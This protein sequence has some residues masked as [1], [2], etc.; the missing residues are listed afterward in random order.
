MM[1]SE[2]SP[3]L[4]WPEEAER[5]VLGSILAAACVSIDCGRRVLGEAQ[6]AGLAEHHFW[7]QSH[8]GLFRVLCGIAA[9]GLPLDPVS[10]A[11]E[12]DADHADPL[13]ISRLRVLAH[14]VTAITS[15]R[16]HAS[17]VVEAAIRREI[18]R[19]ANHG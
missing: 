18:A 17:I 10:V 5:S 8:G 2:T 3:S 16:R 19:S 1:S 11:A 15:C 7:L 6:A 13:L 14:E 9:Q 4:L 12:L